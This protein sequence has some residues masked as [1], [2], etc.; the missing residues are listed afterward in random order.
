MHPLRL[1]YTCVSRPSERLRKLK[2]SH[3]HPMKRAQFS[4]GKACGDARTSDS[5]EAPLSLT[6]Y[7]LMAAMRH[8]PIIETVFL[9]AGTRRILDNDRPTNI[10]PSRA[11]PPPFETLPLPPATN[12]N[13]SIPKPFQVY[14]LQ[15]QQISHI[16]ERLR[17]DAR[18]RRRTIRSPHDRSFRTT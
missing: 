9:T 16:M 17:S 4:L 6:N 8:L 3:D 12:S 13:N 11:P 15:P 7:Y 14:F 1:R 2:R 18:C 5:R 10:Q